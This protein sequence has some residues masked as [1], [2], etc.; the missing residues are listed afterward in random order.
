MGEFGDVFLSLATLTVLEVVLGIDNLI[1]L[2]I[3]TQNLPPHQRKKARQ[4][5]LT[6]AWVTRLL[7]LVSAIYI[8]KLTVPL[9]SVFN[10][11][12]SGRDLFLLLGGLFLVGKATQEIHHEIEPAEEK[13]GV[14]RKSSSFGIVITQIAILDIIF[15]LDSILTAIGLT[16]NFWIMAI[17][18]TIAILAMIFASEPLSRFVEKNPTVKMLALSFLILI[19]TV[20]IADGLHFHIPRGYIY[21]ALGYSIF[22]EMLNLAN[23]RRKQ[24]ARK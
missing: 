10:Y 22:V 17:A 14:L 7:L 1:F 11:T 18:I 9:F 13:S 16:T 12:L 21:F 15:S 23:K 5:G 2:T 6:F 19:G 3:T 4:M 24:N 8:T 20:L